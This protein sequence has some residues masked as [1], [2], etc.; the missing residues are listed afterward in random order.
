L[1]SA[2][3]SSTWSIDCSSVASSSMIAVVAAP[4]RLISRASLLA[5]P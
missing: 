2:R 3:R 5:V 4:S 1:I